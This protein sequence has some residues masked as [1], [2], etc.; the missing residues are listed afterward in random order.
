LTS[1]RSGGCLGLETS[2]GLGQLL[3]LTQH[4]LQSSALLH[5]ANQDF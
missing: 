5:N 1:R 3:D 4:G 2:K